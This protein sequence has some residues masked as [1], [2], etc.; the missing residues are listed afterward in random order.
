MTAPGTTWSPLRSRDFLLYQAARLLLTLGVQMQSTAMAWYVYDLTH[1]PLDLGFVGL[2]QFLPA[3]SLALVTGHVADRFERHRILVLCFAALGACAGIF[4]ALARGGNH[5]VGA[6]Y[7][8]LALVGA[9]RAF[10][11]PAA[12][13]FLPHLV[14]E[15]HLA[16]GVAWN[17][18]VFQVAQIAG[19]S[20]GG[21]LYG[22][23]E[24]AAPV[25][26]I[27]AGSILLATGCLA[28]IRARSGRMETRAA[29][30]QLLLEGIRYVR[31]QRMILGAIS[32]DLFAVLL[33]GAVALLPVYARDILRAGPWGLGLLRSAPAVGAGTVAVVLGARPLQRKAGPLMLGCVA[34]FGAGTI[35]FGLSR[36]IWLSVLALAVIGAAD[37]VS[38]VVRITMVQLG[39]P[40]SMRGRVSAVNSVFIGASNE[41]GEFESGVTAAWMGAVPAVVVGGVGTLVVVAL[42]TLL[43]PELRKIDRLEDISPPAVSPPG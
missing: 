7:A 37:M 17:A 18:S 42:W 28:A 26:G 11:G 30:G 31:R 2:A 32:M 20:L 9:A 12:Q 36:A 35:A 14:P 29:S 4:F 6:V 15:G 16:R 34:V 24:S 41:L 22:L 1:R 40:P 19:P 33:G 23:S 5:S 43:F 21:A 13:S 39:T 25:F 3:A 10:S 8:V 27:A 38:V